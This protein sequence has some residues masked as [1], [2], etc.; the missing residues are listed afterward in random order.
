MSNISTRSLIRDFSGVAR[1]FCLRSF[2]L[3][4]YSKVATIYRTRKIPRRLWRHKLVRQ[5]CGSPARHARQICTTENGCRA[6]ENGV[7]QTG[8]PM[9]IADIHVLSE[10][11]CTGSCPR[12]PITLYHPSFGLHDNVP[13]NE[14]KSKMC[15]A[16]DL[17]NF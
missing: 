6:S 5:R 16:G 1:S 12:P 11:Q 17:E 10:S 7:R 2:L 15:R 14:Q 8:R 13:K 9:Q 4:R 3:S